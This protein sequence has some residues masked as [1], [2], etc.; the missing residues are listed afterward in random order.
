MRFDFTEWMA[1]V[2]QKIT[3]NYVNKVLLI[4]SCGGPIILVFVLGTLSVI[5][6]VVGLNH[7][8]GYHVVEFNKIIYL[9]IKLEFNII[10]VY[11]HLFF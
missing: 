8:N 5:D 4:Y 7:E 9:C 10:Y 6:D 1:L 11:F 3:L 2:S